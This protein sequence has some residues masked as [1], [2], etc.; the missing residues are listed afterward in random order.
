MQ[1]VDDGEKFTIGFDRTNQ[2]VTRAVREMSSEE[3]VAA[4]NLHVAALDEA[5]VR[6]LDRL[7]RLIS[8]SKKTRRTD[9]G[10]MLGTR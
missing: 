10:S 8:R 4:I 1:D 9:P 6:S 5:D 2:P 3:L 7:R